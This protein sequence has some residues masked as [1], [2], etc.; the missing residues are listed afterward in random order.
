MNNKKKIEKI[1]N[2]ALNSLSLKFEGDFNL[3][4]PQDLKHGE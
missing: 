2:K 1:L 4:H 3:E